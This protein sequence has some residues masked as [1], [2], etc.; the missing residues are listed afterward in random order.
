MELQR[1]SVKP[2]LFV[3]WNQASIILTWIS[4]GL[5]FL[6]NKNHFFCIMTI[7]SAE[8]LMFISYTEKSHIFSFYLNSIGALKHF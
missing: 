1:K 7:A 2:N 6:Y 5:C 4:I 3:I 8:F